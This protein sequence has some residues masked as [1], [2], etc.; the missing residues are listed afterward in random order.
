MNSRQTIFIHIPRTAG[1]SMGKALKAHFGDQ[2]QDLGSPLLPKCN[3]DS[4]VTNVQ[5]ISVQS[6]VDRGV[7]TREW[8]DSCFVFAFIRNPWDRLA[9][10]FEHLQYRIRRQKRQRES[11]KYLH[12]FE[13]FAR[14][15]CQGFYVNPIGRLATDDWSQANPQTRWLEQGVSFVGAYETLEEDWDDVCDM[16]GIPTLPLELHNKSSKQKHYREYYSTELVDLVGEF[17]E[18][19]VETWGYEF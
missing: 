16:I 12:S 19:D 4:A 8:Y 6:L 18:E 2:Y 7:F 1:K 17:Y 5:H 13:A 9:S 15:V 3:C 11:N 10:L 14:M